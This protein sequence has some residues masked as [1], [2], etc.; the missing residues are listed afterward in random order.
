M[1]ASAK[2]LEISGESKPEDPVRVP[3]MESGL[4]SRY[5]TIYQI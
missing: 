1:S 5:K 4:K 2:T 3:T